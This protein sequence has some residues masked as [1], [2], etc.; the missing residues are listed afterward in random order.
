MR[1]GVVFKCDI[2]AEYEGMITLKIEGAGAIKAF[3]NESGGHRYQRKSPTG[4]GEKHSS[5][6]T[7]A[8]LP[9]FKFNEI[10]IR[11]SDCEIT[12]CRGSRP[13]GQ[14]RN[15]T[16]SA[17]Q[18]KH[19]PSGLIVRCETE[20]SQQQNKAS[21]MSLLQARL[22]QMNFSTYK[23][24]ESQSRKSQIG[25]GERS[26]KIRTVQFQNGHVVNHLNGKKIPIEKY[27][28]GEIEC[29]W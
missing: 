3:E 29:L 20:R 16:D 2:V 26:D 9:V 6:I 21:A 1:N 14:N 4:K 18:I 17:V 12:T 15:K 7:V 27:F 10:T 13:G 23:D 19:K 11:E 25:K 8:V 28:K 22:N 24:K 5:T